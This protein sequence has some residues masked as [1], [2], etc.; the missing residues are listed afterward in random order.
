VVEVRAEAREP[1]DGA[2]SRWQ[3]HIGKLAY[4]PA[5]MYVKIT[6]ADEQHLA[7]VA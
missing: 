3:A 2:L 6:G 5:C 4:I 7:D 1:V